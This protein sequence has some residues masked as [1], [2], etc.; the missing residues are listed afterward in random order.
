MLDP[1]TDQGRALLENMLT[2]QAAIIAY[3]NAFK[4]MMAATLLAFPLILLVRTHQPAI[5]PAR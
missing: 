3:S 2:Q 1:T 5:A 4:L